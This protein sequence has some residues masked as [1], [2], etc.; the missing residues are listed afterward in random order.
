M[1]TV[2]EREQNEHETTSTNPRWYDRGDY[3]WLLL[4]VGGALILGFCIYNDSVRNTTVEVITST[5]DSIAS[6]IEGNGD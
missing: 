1:A 6:T 3:N 2:T 4:V 5:T